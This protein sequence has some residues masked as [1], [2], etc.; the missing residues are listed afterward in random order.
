[1]E[2]F[3]FNELCGA[4]ALAAL[5][6]RKRINREE[7]VC[8]SQNANALTVKQAQ[9]F[10]SSLPSSNSASSMESQGFIVATRNDRNSS[11]KDEL[12]PYPFFYYRDHSTDSDPDPLEP[13]TPPGR[14]PTFPAKLYA[15]LARP[16]LED[17]VAW[18]PHGRAW[19]VLK[20]REF[21][22]KVIPRFFEHAK[23]SSF[24]RQAN[25]S[26]EYETKCSCAVNQVAAC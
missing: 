9:A 23:F 4:P 3:Q 7:D 20:P 21:E 26:V 8:A 15:I 6:A 24:I 22:T 17:V 1:M 19:R 25:V 16:E 2:G 5:L 12:K 11:G 14:V 18:L 13:L 10:L